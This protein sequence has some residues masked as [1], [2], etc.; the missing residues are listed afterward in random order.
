MRIGG[1]S[2]AITIHR[3]SQKH[4]FDVWCGGMLE[5]GIGKAYNIAFASLPNC[6]LPNDLRPPTTFLTQ[7]LLKND[8]MMTNGTITP[9]DQIGMG[10]RVDEK[11]IKKHTIVKI[12]L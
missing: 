8:I 3:L 12:L 5:T 2:E 1:L 9:S 11:V 6:K 10:Y 7:D 4:N